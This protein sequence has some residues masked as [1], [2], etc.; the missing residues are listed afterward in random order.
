MPGDVISRPR[1]L[2]LLDHEAPLTVVRGAAG[3]GKTVV[4]HEWAHHA[5]ARIAWITADAES[6]D[7]PG[8]ARQILRRLR[9]SSDP[10][11]SGVDHGWKAVR[12]CVGDH[13]EPVTVVVDDAAT[14]QREAL[15]DLC[16]AVAAAPRLRVIAATNRR[17][18]LDSDGVAL[19]LDRSVIGPAELMFD[20]AEV[21]R[22]LDVDA[23]VARKILAAT[24]GFPAVIHALAKRRLP[25]G[26]ESLLQVAVE[27]VEEYM[28]LR[29][30]RSGY[31][32]ALIATLAR[33]GFAEVLD[34]TLARELGGSPQAVR[35]L[36]QA[37]SY[38]FGAWSSADSARL[39]RFAPFA[40]ALLKREL[41]RHHSAELPA[42][43]R[44]V[45]DWALKKNRP[46]D[47][48]QVA[49]E[50]DDLAM[51]RRVAIS[52]W[53]RLLN[54][55]H[56]VRRILGAVPLSQL[57]DEPLL[58][59]LLAVC[60]HAV[61]VR[62][63]RGLQLFRVAVS[64][65][66]SQRSD[67]SASD[68]LFIWVAE[69]AALRV[70]GLPERAAS[71]AVR[72]LRLLADTSEE[73]REPYATQVPLLCAQMGIS[74]YYGGSKRQAIECF[75][76]GAAVATADAYEHAISN[77]SMLSGIHALDGDLPKARHY[78][79]LVRDREWSRGHLDG[80]QGTFYRVA[81]AILAIEDSDAARAAQ[82]TATFQP[83][84]ETSEHWL[85]MAT[86]EALVALRLGRAAMGAEQLESLVELRGR[87]GHNATARRSLSQVRTLLQLAL[88]N[89]QAAKGV[90]HKDAPDDRF[91]T[92]V[93][94]ARIAL[95]DDRPRDTLRILSQ[96]GPAPTT[97]RLRAEALAL[98]TAALARTGGAAG[99]RR[100]AQTLGALLCDRG[101]RLPLAFL[102]QPDAHATWEILT[103]EAACPIEP[104]ESVLSESPSTPPLTGRERVV[105]RALTSGKPLT[106][107]ATDLGVSPNT[108]KTQVKSVYRKLGVAGREEAV[109]AAFARH[110]LADNG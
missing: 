1:L 91:E 53:D 13:D 4:L 54:H 49:I 63:L 100:E 64:A 75:S 33:L 19:L 3:S 68:R 87:E 15:V 12:D 46:A 105:L 38:G 18:V 110:L 104:V 34:E 52:S 57:G 11:G 41:E 37:E 60:Y 94:R 16:E 32:P 22:A 56:E 101:L 96:T 107:I 61:G 7:S 74:L 86:V 25:D 23:E 81:E 43:R 90:L 29:V 77:L 85:A 78:V 93:E 67:L 70:L 20:D 44:V 5:D 89:T 99:A 31:D 51:A 39:F 103:K 24:N 14:L 108:V 21:R 45:V 47:A 30:S 97:P 80:Y 35:F 102:P 26:D 42:L 55:G 98:R 88:G 62:R 84:R 48:L 106:A 8:L 40:R 95:V 66:N 58:V 76:Y 50:G 28:R 109:A 82:H 36:D 59:M 27:A 9:G 83:H 79:Q 92:M 6:A 2:A 17:T 10:E 73:D 72:A 71:V 69:S 65:A